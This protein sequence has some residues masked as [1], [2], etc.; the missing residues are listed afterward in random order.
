MSDRRVVIDS[1]I[2]IYA[3]KDPGG[4]FGKFLATA[5]FAFSVV[6]RIEVLGFPKLTEAERD[7]LQQLLQ[8]GSELPLSEDIADRAIALR[9]SR[10]MSLG[11]SIVA[12]TALS[13]GLTLATRNLGDFHWIVELTIDPVLPSP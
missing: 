3:A 10:S 13:H 6:T 4:V 5:S 2:I 1:N 11:D 12:A 8:S 9:Q 7:A